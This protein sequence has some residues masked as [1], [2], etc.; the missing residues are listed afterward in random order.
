MINNN[1]GKKYKLGTKENINYLV[2]LEWVKEN[3]IKIIIKINIINDFIINNYFTI[4]TLEKILLENDFLKNIKSVIDLINYFGEI[5]SN[6]NIKIERINEFIYSLSLF[7]NLNQKEIKFELKRK[8]IEEELLLMYK[9]IE[10]MEKEV[11]LNDLKLEQLKKYGKMESKMD[12]EEFNDQTPININNNSNNININKLRNINNNSSNNF[13]NETKNFYQNNDINNNLNQNN[14]NNNNYNY[15]NQSINK[16]SIGFS[17]NDNKNNIIFN[18]NNE[19]QNN[20]NLKINNKKDGFNNNLPYTNSNF[21]DKKL[22]TEINVQCEIFTAFNLPNGHPIIIWTTNLKNNEI[23]LLNLSS[24][25]KSYKEAHRKQINN[26]QYFHNEN[27]NELSECLISLSKQDEEILKLWIIIGELKIY[28]KTIIKFSFL[29]KKIEKFCVFVNSNYSKDNVFL[30]IY[31]ED[32]NNAK[33]K[34]I[35]YYN[36]DNR[37]KILNI[38]NCN[39][40]FKYIYKTNEKINYL[41]S[42]YYLGQKKLYLINCNN[43]NLNLLQNPFNNYTKIYFNTDK[44]NKNHIAAFILEKENYIQIFDL[45]S[46]GIYIWIIKDTFPE[47]IITIS[48]YN[49][50]IYDFLIIN[51]NY[52]LGSS[53]EGLILIQINEAKIIETLKNSVDKHFPKIKKIVNDKGISILSLDPDKKLCMWPFINDH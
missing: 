40:N 16:N 14:Y 13:I 53:E 18:R 32:N 11:K 17:V 31:G 5:I 42:F 38:E 12:H 4:E 34:G 9:K 23:N 22:I 46:E 3:K 8:D 26:L 36:L 45:N 27:S 48:L 39:T 47:L 10:E 24:N 41:D 15:Q 25:L 51:N 28:V 49:K 21:E 29:Q 43:D 37:L 30:I 2:I 1:Y 19:N 20:K 33:D 6:K 44:S 7:D 52:L 50:K 35:F